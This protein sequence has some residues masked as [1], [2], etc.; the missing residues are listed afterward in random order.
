MH[1]NFSV[2]D[3]GKLLFMQFYN[4]NTIFF[5]KVVESFSTTNLDVGIT[6]SWEVTLF[7]FS[8]DIPGC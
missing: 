2:V 7:A 5:C 6:F 3:K 4:I 1:V 8:T